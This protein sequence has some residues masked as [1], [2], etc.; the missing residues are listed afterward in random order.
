LNKKQVL[1]RLEIHWAEFNA[2]FSGLTEAQMLV[3]GITSAW[4][5][6]DI[7]AHVSTWEEEALKNLPLILQNQKLPRYK[8]QYGGLDAFNAQ[9]TDMKRSFSL[10]NI[11]KQSDTIH[12]QL[13]AFLNSVPEDM[14][15]SET[16][17]RHRLRLD[18]YSH[19]LIHA[20]AIREWR[21][22]LI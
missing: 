12:R 5:V 11:L 21:E 10:S 8:N 13:T 6:K 15:I 14:F 7:I 9:M 18:T 2:S 20:K 3:P 4:S 22:N 19:Y 17:F 16:R 1:N